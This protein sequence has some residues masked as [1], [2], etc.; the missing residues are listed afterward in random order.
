M[1]TFRWDDELQDAKRM[2]RWFVCGCQPHVRP[3]V[4][5]CEKWL[6]VVWH[7]TPHVTLQGRPT[8]T[9]N[10]IRRSSWLEGR[11]RTVGID[12]HREKGS[13]A[14]SGRM[15]SPTGV[16]P[17]DV[18]LPPIGAAEE[19][20]RVVLQASMGPI[21]GLPRC[22]VTRGFPPSLRVGPPNPPV[23]WHPRAPPFRVQLEGAHWTDPPEVVRI[24]PAWQAFFD[25]IPSS[26]GPHHQPPQLGEGKA[27]QTRCISMHVRDPTWNPRG[28][29]EKRTRSRTNRGPVVEP[30]RTHQWME[31]LQWTGWTSD[32]NQ[33][34]QGRH[35]GER[36]LHAAASSASP[37]IVSMTGFVGWRTYTSGGGIHNPL[38]EP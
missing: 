29:V 1:P 5:R 15:A 34:R 12:A 26:W 24:D 11:I 38:A 7:C 35:L 2:L 22:H 18:R 23:T 28:N 9:E 16:F 10:R 32:P 33:A 13:S 19:P 31:P 27:K 37:R 3:P 6:G 4:A 20:G 17:V 25:P 21:V 36:M 8:P 14:P 30:G